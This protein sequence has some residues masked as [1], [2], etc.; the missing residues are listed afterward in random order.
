MLHARYL[1]KEGIR[2]AEP[3]QD[4]NN[5][6]LALLVFMDYMELHGKSITKFIEIINNQ[7][8]KLLKQ[9]QV[10]SKQA[11]EALHVYVYVPLAADG[12][13]RW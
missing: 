9:D 10:E 3:V 12:V 11:I 6:D 7:V 4:C 8:N 1:I 2:M 13:L 5:H